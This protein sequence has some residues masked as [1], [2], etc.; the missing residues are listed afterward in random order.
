MQDQ[1]ARWDPLYKKVKTSGLTEDEKAEVWI[2]LVKQPVDEVSVLFRARDLDPVLRN[3]LSGIVYAEA[4]WCYVSFVW[5]IC[6]LHVHSALPQCLI[7]KNQP[8]SY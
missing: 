5:G 3:V 6:W 4:R 2:E 1:L 8:I 7:S